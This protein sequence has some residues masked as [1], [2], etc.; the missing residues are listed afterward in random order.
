MS[1]DADTLCQECS[2]RIVLDDNSLRDCQTETE[3][4][5]PTLRIGYY[6]IENMDQPF[7]RFDEL[8][9]L[10]SLTRSANNGCKFCS[11][12]RSAVQSSFSSQSGPVTLQFK[13]RWAESP[14]DTHGASLYILAALQV[15]AVIPATTSSQKLER[16]LWFTIE[17]SEGMK[18][19]MSR[20]MLSCD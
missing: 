2:D 12:L 14:D 17:A 3:S 7:E 6:D 5:T 9:D 13:F 18:P 4:Q 11:L 16:N 15:I 8:P 1:L 10:P 19:L 20:K